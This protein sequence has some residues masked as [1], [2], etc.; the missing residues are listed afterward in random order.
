VTPCQH[1]AHARM[2]CSLPLRTRLAP[3]WQRP[4]KRVGRA[5]KRTQEEKERLRKNLSASRGTP[6]AKPSS[7]AKGSKARARTGKRAE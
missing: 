5:G 4:D 3:K 7:T 2:I 6:S 1:A